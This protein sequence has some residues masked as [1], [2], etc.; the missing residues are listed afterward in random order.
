MHHFRTLQLSYIIISISTAVFFVAVLLGISNF[1]Y[2]FLVTQ[3]MLLLLVTA[4]DR[5]SRRVDRQ[6]ARILI[7]SVNLIMSSLFMITI[8]WNIPDIVLGKFAI[9]KYVLVSVACLVA[10][11]AAVKAFRPLLIAS[12]S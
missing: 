4:A 10:A 8:F 1:N 9:A 11:F 3:G 7:D 12:R 2:V 6:S 5:V